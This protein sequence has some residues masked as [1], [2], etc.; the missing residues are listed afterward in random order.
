MYT[1]RRLGRGPSEGAGR[2][3]KG[4]NDAENESARAWG[5]VWGLCVYKSTSRPGPER[6][7]KAPLTS[8]SEVVRATRAGASGRLACR[9]RRLGTVR[10][11]R[12]RR[13][14]RCGGPDQS[15][16]G[17]AHRR[18]PAPQE[19]RLRTAEFVVSQRLL[20]A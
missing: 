9:R 17:L 12:P 13:R 18:V 16:A 1:G 14:H 20:T 11:R 7:A 3:A 2:G 4:A 19:A 5:Q 6:R 15:E 10:A 8:S